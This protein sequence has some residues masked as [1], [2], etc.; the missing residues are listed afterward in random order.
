MQLHDVSKAIQKM[1]AF[2]FAYTQYVASIDSMAMQLIWSEKY[3]TGRNLID[4]RL[5]IERSRHVPD[6]NTTKVS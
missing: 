6:L 5:N 2:I 3:I 4:S 1:W